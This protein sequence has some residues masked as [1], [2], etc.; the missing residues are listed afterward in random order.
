M[1]LF[2][3]S[4]VVGLALA[5]TGCPGESKPAAGGAPTTP[6]TDTTKP[7]AG[8]PAE[9]A[10][11]AEPAKSD[12]KLP[13]YDDVKV[14]QKYIY[15]MSNNMS[16]IDEVKSRDDEKIVVHMS[17]K[18]P[19]VPDQPP[20]PVEYKLKAAKP[21]ATATPTVAPPKSSG[22]ETITVS[23]VS[24]E[25]EIYESEAGGQKMKAWSSKKFP[26]TIKSEMNGA[27]SL[28]LKEIK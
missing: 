12:D 7:E 3:I 11:P 23:G 13:G 21:E 9:A 15:A 18:M 25:C 4:L 10:K 27:V 24:F 19:N 14:G 5:L 26:F 6:P 8:K 16:R 17:M 1:R 22:K 2:S 20:S 28:E